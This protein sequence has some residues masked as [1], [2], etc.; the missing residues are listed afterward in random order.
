MFTELPLKSIF[1]KVITLSLGLIFC[2]ADAVISGDNVA[3]TPVDEEVRYQAT[4]HDS[5]QNNYVAVGADSAGNRYLEI[6]QKYEGIHPQDDKPTL[7]VI[8]KAN[9]L[10]Y[11]GY[12]YTHNRSDGITTLSFGGG[13]LTVSHRYKRKS[14]GVKYSHVWVEWIYH[15]SIE[16]NTLAQQIYTLKNASY[17]KWPASR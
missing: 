10:F 2:F 14:T 16:A 6:Y 5:L 11:E 3:A 1:C 9:L 12:K 7:V 4:P 8:P 15:V 17:S 13:V